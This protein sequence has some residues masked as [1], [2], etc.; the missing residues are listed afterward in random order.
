MEGSTE[1]AQFYEGGEAPPNP[2]Q[3]VMIEAPGH[4]HDDGLVHAHGWARSPS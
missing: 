1:S 4:D 2:A 3:D